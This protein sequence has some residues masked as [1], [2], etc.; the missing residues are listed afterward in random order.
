LLLVRPSSLGVGAARR[1]SK[2]RKV[3]T[4]R[5]TSVIRIIR[6][7]VIPPHEYWPQKIS[8]SSEAA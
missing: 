7:I 5:R 6:L 2:L 3:V 4:T 8:L 1:L